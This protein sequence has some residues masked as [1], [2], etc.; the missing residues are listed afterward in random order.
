MEIGDKKE[1]KGMANDYWSNLD[2]GY[3][4]SPL[5]GGSVNASGSMLSDYAS[6]KNGS[7]GKLM[8]AYCARKDAE[9]AASSASSDTAQKLTLMGTG[10]AA[11]KKSAEALGDSALWEKKKITKK[12][13]ETGEE[14]ETEDYDWDAITKAVKSFVEDYNAVV[15]QAGSSDT[16]KVLQQ[17]S[18]IHI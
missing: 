8:K 17:L 9:K 16:K 7:Y 11:L 15:E 4:V 5:F 12:D 14:I 2:S 3:D 13:E 6:I 18:L 1:A 10:A